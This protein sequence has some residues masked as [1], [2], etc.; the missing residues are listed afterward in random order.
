MEE[1]FLPAGLKI[2]SSNI[3]LTLSDSYSWQEPE[4]DKINLGESV[5]YRFMQSNQLI[6]KS[7][8]IVLASTTVSISVVHDMAA[9]V[10]DR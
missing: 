7:N 6:T 5:L 10:E 8:Y 4:K 9:Y 1:R 2:G 3:D